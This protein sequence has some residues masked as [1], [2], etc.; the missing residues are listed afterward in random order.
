MLVFPDVT[1]LDLTGPFEVLSRIQGAEVRLCGKD[2]EPV[3]SDSGLLLTPDAGLEDAAACQ[4]DIVMVPGGRGVN[5]LLGDAGVL[6][7]LRGQAPGAR[8]MASVCT[9]ALVLGAAGLLRGYRATTHWAS[10]EFLAAFGATPVHSRVVVDRDRI[11]GAGVTAGIDFALSLAAL[12]ESERAAR[13]IQLQLEYDPEPPF[14]E[15]D[16]SVRAAV[17]ARLAPVLEERRAA[18]LLAA[19]KLR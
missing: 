6:A 18:V 17:R 2:R 7:F 11:T 1:Q 4:F 13:Q 14:D 15:P 16:E 10:H 12:A 3:R 8:W 19:A 9:G 5:P